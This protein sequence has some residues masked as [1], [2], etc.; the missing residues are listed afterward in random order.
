MNL[1]ST[2]ENNMETLID[3]D[4]IRNLFKQAIIEA[5]EEKKDFVHDLFMD[6]MEDIAMIR[7][8][9]EGEKTD[10]V[11]RDDVFNVLNR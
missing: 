3:D 8:I 7:A 10:K 1:L 4:K 5:I 2:V 9:E 11:S 6:A